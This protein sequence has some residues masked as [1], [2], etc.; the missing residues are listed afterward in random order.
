MPTVTGM[1]PEAAPEPASHDYYNIGAL[2]AADYGQ[3]VA[4]TCTQRLDA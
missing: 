1:S 4:M 3:V 2:L